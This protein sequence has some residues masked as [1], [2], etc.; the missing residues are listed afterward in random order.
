L[1]RRVRLTPRYLNDARQCGVLGGT[2]ESRDVK[3]VIDVLAAA[4]AESLGADIFTYVPHENEAVRVLAHGR[5]VQQR[6]LWLWYWARDDELTLVGLT[7]VPP[8]PR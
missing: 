3:R 7:K 6:N 1:A 8:V 2:P 5:R 4:S